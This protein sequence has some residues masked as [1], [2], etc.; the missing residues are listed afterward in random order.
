[1]YDGDARVSTELPRYGPL[2]PILT[3]QS[4]R[5]MTSSPVYVRS[6]TSETAPQ[7]TFWFWSRKALVK[8]DSNSLER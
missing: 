3:Y 7:E 6:R 5:R 2:G 8:L 4:A 1:M